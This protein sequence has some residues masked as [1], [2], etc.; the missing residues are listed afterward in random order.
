ME[1]PLP[2][3]KWY[4]Q[5]EDRITNGPNLGKFGSTWSTMCKVDLYAAGA[6]FTEQTPI[7]FSLYRQP[8][9]PT[10]ETPCEPTKHNKL[11]LMAS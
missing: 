9:Q 2:Y 5:S 4:R 10:Y 3:R 6:S 11:L 8:T 1:R 7:P